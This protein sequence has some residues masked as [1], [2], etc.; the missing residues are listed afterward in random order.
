MSKRKAGR[1]RRV[2]MDGYWREQLK[3]PEFKREYEALEPE[4][5]IRRQ[6]IDRRL[7]HNLSQRQLADK[8]GTPRPG[9]SRMEAKGVKDLAFAQ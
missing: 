5:S 7:K 2:P 6:L 9:I 3:D 1:A 4:F 8:V